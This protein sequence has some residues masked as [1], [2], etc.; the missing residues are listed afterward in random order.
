MAD[1]TD[2][3]RDY[4]VHRDDVS[5][6]FLFGSRT[7]EGQRHRSDSDWD[8]AVYFAPP[9]SRMLEWEEEHRWPAELELW[10]DLDRILGAS[11]DLV[12]LNRAPASLSASIVCDGVPLAVRDPGLLLRFQSLILDEAVAFRRDLEDYWRLK[13]SSSSLS[14]ATRQRLIRLL[15]FVQDGLQEF[16]KFAQ[17]TWEQYRDDAD[18]RRN[19]E[20]WVETLI[21]AVIDMAKV[22]ASSAGRPVPQTYRQMVSELASLPGFD[23]PCVQALARWTRLRNL[24]AHEYLD[25]RWDSLRDF[26]ENAPASL[27]SVWQSANDRL[28]RP[29]KS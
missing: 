2:R 23:S 20:R 24:L 29:K 7:Q 13:Q 9:S 8:V 10:E 28:Q 17:V 18:M 14:P 21:Q 26:V 5:F 22:L 3:L 27:H 16:G 4:F 11:V 1:T 12:V 6:A 19:L 15:D 25:L